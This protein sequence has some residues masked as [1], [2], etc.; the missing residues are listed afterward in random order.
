MTTVYENGCTAPLNLTLGTSVNDGQIYAHPLYPHRNN[1]NRPAGPPRPLWALYRR[2]K[3]LDPAENRST[4]LRSFSTQAR[5]CTVLTIPALCRTCKVKDCGVKATNEVRSICRPIRAKERRRPSFRLPLQPTSTL[6]GGKN[7]GTFRYI[8]W[9]WQTSS[10]G[11]RVT[12]TVVIVKAAQHTVSLENIS[13]DRFSL[14]T[15]TEHSVADRILR[16]S[17]EQSLKTVSLL[18][19]PYG[20]QNTIHQKKPRQPC[21]I[22]RPVKGKKVPLQAWSDP[23]GSRK[24]RFPD[25]M[26]TA[27]N[28]DEVVSL[29]HQSPLPSGNTPGTHFC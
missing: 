26:T 4:I 2:E 21:A 10:S 8:G 24:L 12:V 29:M 18:S 22:T 15:L 9:G 7:E 11:V 16:C 28:G 17:S 23:E 13:S 6:N 27:Q 25:F 5:Q 20:S 19:C 14:S 3:P 1:N